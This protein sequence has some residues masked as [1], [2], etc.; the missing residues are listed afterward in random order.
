[1]MR[2][3][4][5]LFIPVLCAA[6][7]STATYRTDNLNGGRVNTGSVSTSNGDSTERMQSING[8]M[9]PLEQTSEKVLRDDASGKVVERIIKRYDS[10]GKLIE[11]QRVLSEE[12]PVRNGAK[13]MKESVSVTDYNGRSREIER[14]TTQTQTTGNTTTTNISVDRSNPNGAFQPAERRNI[15][16][17][18]DDR[19]Q[20]SHEVVQMPDLNGRM[21][22]AARTDSIT[23]VT[24]DR[25]VS[26]STTFEPDATGKMALKEQKVE[27]TV[28]RPGGETVETS[29]YSPNATPQMRSAMESNVHI[30]EQRIVERQIGAD[31]S[32]REST[33]VRRPG[34][35]P[36]RL[37]PAQKISETACS[38]K[39]RPDAPK[40]EPAKPTATASTAKRN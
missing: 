10:T 37:G 27:T 2:V 40:P 24:G 36:D 33:S 7:S 34:A 13:T 25:K 15:V 14:R 28:K 20:E 9:V 11:T 4:L 38:G 21:R 26:N 12:T 29:L 19:K 6:Q 35:D 1:M 17:T 18:G 31:G 23:Q 30:R 16:A 22:D 5:A 8:R 3:L 32:V 39:C